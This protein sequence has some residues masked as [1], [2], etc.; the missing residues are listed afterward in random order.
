MVRVFFY[1]GDDNLIDQFSPNVFNGRVGEIVTLSYFSFRDD[2]GDIKKVY[3]IV[4][5][6][7]KFSRHTY[8][9][10]DGGETTS[11]GYSIRVELEEV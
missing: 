1:D 2:L 6:K 4:E 5:V 11:D 8:D 3:E 7:H 10:V 9:H